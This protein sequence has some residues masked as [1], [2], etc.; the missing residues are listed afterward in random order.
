MSTWEVRRFGVTFAYGPAETMP[1]AEEIE[2]FRNGGY[3]VYLDGRL[4]ADQPKRV[5]RVTESKRVGKK[6]A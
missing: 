2:M 5:K 1:D 3:E 4:V 6:S